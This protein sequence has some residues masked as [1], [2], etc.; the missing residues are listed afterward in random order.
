[1]KKIVIVTCSSF[2]V[3]IL[4]YVLFSVI[5]VISE[6]TNEKV[7]QLFS[8]TLSIA[9][10]MSVGEWIL[11]KLDV[12]S[13]AL[14]AVIRVL[15]CYVVVFAEGTLYGMFPFGWSSLFYISLIIIPTVVTTY[16]IAYV[17]V[18]NY[19]KQINRNRQ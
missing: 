14:D 6:V 16:A 4:L 11:D 18:V 3:T 15:I 12:S 17:T 8:M 2:T 10:L 1:M 7:L 13:L 5:G 9:L 19:A